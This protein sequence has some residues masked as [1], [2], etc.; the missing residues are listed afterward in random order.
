MPQTVS[1]VGSAPCG[2]ALVPSQAS[3][4]VRGRFLRI[5]GEGGSATLSEIALGTFLMAWC[6]ILLDDLD[7]RFQNVPS[8]L[9]WE[10]TTVLFSNCLD[11]D[12]EPPKLVYVTRPARRGPIDR[13]YA[14]PSGGRED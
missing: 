12:S 11:I 7:A 6:A 5:K 10:R 14:A 3:D 9:A 4:F 1:H 2:Y 8:V 13:G